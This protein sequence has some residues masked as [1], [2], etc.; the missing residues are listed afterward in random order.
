M[1]RPTVRCGRKWTAGLQSSSAER[2]P[3]QIRKAVKPGGL[4]TTRFA[5]SPAISEDDTLRA[6]FGD[7]HGPRLHGF[8]L[9]VSLGDARR[10]EQAVGDAM[11]V[12]TDHAAALR[13]PERAASWLRARTLGRL[14]HARL[15][16][17]SPSTTAR[18]AALQRLGVD[19]ATFNALARLSPVGR[20][21]VA[22][23]IIERFEPMDV[24]TILGT[25]A[26]NA[27]RL[28]ARANRRCLAAMADGWHAG[29]AAPVGELGRRVHSMAERGFAKTRAPL[30]S[31]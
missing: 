20:A 16:G 8:A 11:A 31:A 6:A 21:A 30:K 10:A 14:R 15:F 29:A 7:L 27:R 13:H 26:G 22:A 28:V 9:I 12:G 1:G 4:A 25:S 2:T 5:R 23:T 18:R 24:E 17:R 3:Q 19:E